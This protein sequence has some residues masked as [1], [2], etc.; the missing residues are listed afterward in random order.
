MGPG[1]YTL[2]IYLSYPICSTP[3][4]PQN[5]IFFSLIFFQAAALAFHSLPRFTVRMI[6]Y[7]SSR[8]VFLQPKCI[9]TIFIHTP[10]EK[11]IK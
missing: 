5:V 11:H 3:V 4:H 2:I 6:I 7:P 1:R 9:I 8:E 10:E